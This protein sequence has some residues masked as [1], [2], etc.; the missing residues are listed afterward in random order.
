MN[1]RDERILRHVGLYRLSIRAVIERLF[2][3][4]KSCDD[5]I[6]RLV[7]KEK[8]LTVSRLPNRVSFYKLSL[9]AARARGFTDNRA[10]TRGVQT[11]SIRRAL[12]VLWY[13]CM[14][15]NIRH[16][17]ERKDLTQLFAR[18]PG[19][20]IPHCWE[21]Q[22]GVG[23]IVRRIYTPGPN[24]PTDEIL[25]TLHHDGEAA[26]ADLKLAP[27]VLARRYSFV[28][29]VKAQERKELIEEQLEAS[30]A[31][32]VAV[33]VVPD[34]HCLADAIRQYKLANGQSHDE[35]GHNETEE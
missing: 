5:V 8:L 29:L 31:T 35:S 21:N 34:P 18:A 24:T 25:R 26:L 22:H 30:P 6:N 3:D 16:R 17:I 9:T 20:G 28:V 1:E 10:E 14:G 27:L 2:F 15:E 23:R 12:A 19:L 33:E 32:A 4:G 7:A 13:C 11:R